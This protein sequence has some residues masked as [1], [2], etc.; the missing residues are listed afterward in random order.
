MT[1]T[2]E[3]TR[4]RLRIY[5][6][7]APGVGKT[8]AMLDEG[9]RRADRGTDVVVGIVETHGRPHT[10]RMVE[11]HEVIPRRVLDH[12]GSAV[13]EMDVDA[14]LRRRP[15]VALVDELAHS[16][17]PGSRNAK[18][19]QD[20]DEL[21]DA[22]IDVISTVNIQHLES[23]NDVTAQITGVRQRE[24]VP[25]EFVRAADQ[26]ELVD[27]APEALRRRL[28]HGNV[29]RAER[30]D[31]ALSN[32]FRPG[33]LAAL[34]EVALLWLADRVEEG[35]ARYRDD[36]RIT[37]SWATRERIVV[38]L[39]GG[40]ES[41]TVLRR[42]ARIAS[43]GAGGELH[44]VHVG[45][46]DGLAGS[47]LAEV[48]RLKRLTEELGGRFHT[49]TGSSVAESILDFARGLNASQIVIGTSRRGRLS[50]LL[51]P[52]IGD[53][54]VRDSGDIDVHMVTHELAG[55]QPRA[56]RPAPVAGL[57]PR[58]TV[59]G[60]LLGILGVVALTVALSLA[61][62]QPGLP[63]TVQA[64]LVLTVV[65][66]L[67]GGLWPAL[68]TAVVSSLT[69][70]WFFTPPVHT[71]TISSPENALAL[72]AFVLVAGGVASVVHLNARRTAQAEAARAESDTLLELSHSLLSSDHQLQLLL[73]RSVELFGAQ[74]AAVTKGR[75]RDRRVVQA[76]QGWEE[77]SRTADGAG[78]CVIIAGRIVEQI[79]EEHDLVLTGAPTSARD[80][81]LV[82][83]LAA[84]AGAVLARR[85][86]QASASRSDALARDNRARVA[87]LSGVSHDLRSPLAGIKAAIGSLRSSDVEFSEEDRAELM[88][89][90]ET[91]TDRLD[92][93][94][95][96]LLHAS[97]LQLGSLSV[98]ARAVDVAEIR[99]AVLEGVPD[100]DRIVWGVEPGTPAAWAD[101]GLLERV[102]A[103]L[104][105]NAVRHTPPSSP[106]LVQVSAVEDRVEIRV[107]DRGPGIPPEARERIFLPF[108]RYGDVPAGDGVG[109]GLAVARGLTEAMGGTLEAEDTPGGGL[110]MV[111]SLRRATP[112]EGA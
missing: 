100:P 59:A 112:E 52:S 6:G 94:I 18:R 69:I 23:L 78:A 17:A 54:V 86:L 73:D 29:Y 28:A 82:A 51:R 103:N 41:A 104:V 89:A 1:D 72:L 110:T 76:T 62:V 26:V 55:G 30:I 57:S 65:V 45:L 63:L 9:R 109:L 10:T 50:S 96:N 99:P 101:S 3:V 24:T 98:A 32:Y 88:E 93:L 90:I 80:R 14:I 25:D 70:N 83:A 21:L 22:G 74:A 105:E 31:A 13:T 53:S 71:F 85:Q 36:H 35:L 47:D 2:G 95:G 91:S 48:A 38:A 5:L 107:V 60:L 111:V 56:H 97:R 34:R 39:T 66:A 84:H 108:Q 4:G 46:A 15:R 20:V 102:V 87:L 19:W 8:V 42:G 27:M 64:Y 61:G 79:D 7:S 37:G 40:P 77:E 92:A 58:R 43:R 11:G 44:A 33:N 12:R 67:V 75:G 81:R 106:V 49:V 16:N 68:L